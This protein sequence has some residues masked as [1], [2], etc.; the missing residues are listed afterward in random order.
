MTRMVLRCACRASAMVPSGWSIPVSGLDWYS[1]APYMNQGVPP[2]QKPV[3]QILTVWPSWPGAGR[4]GTAK[5]GRAVGAGPGAPLEPPGVTAAEG[6]DT[7]LGVGRVT[8]RPG[9][10]VS[11]ETEAASTARMTAALAASS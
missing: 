9:V 5:V 1:L 6:P 10:Q 8:D 4:E 3:P 7:T 2:K 11:T